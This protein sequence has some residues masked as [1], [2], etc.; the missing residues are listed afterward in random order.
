MGQ[1]LLLQY[2]YKGAHMALDVCERETQAPRSDESEG[3]WY[4]R[5]FHDTTSLNGLRWIDLFAPEIR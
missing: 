1:E 4:H 3:E 5:C 2:L